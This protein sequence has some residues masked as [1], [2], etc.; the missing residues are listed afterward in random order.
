MGVLAKPSA[1]ACLDSGYLGDAVCDYANWV[2]TRLNVPLALLHAIDQHSQPIRTEYSGNLGMEEHRTLLQDIV[3]TEEK[4]NR[5]LIEQG[6]LLLED[7]KDRLACVRKEEPVLLQRHDGI[8]QTLIDLEGM[9]KI[10]V[11]GIRGESQSTKPR[12][13]GTHLEAIIRAIHRPLFIVNSRF[14]APQKFMIAYDG[15]DTA[16]KII[17]KI[18]GYTAFL[19][20]MEC[21]VVSVSETMAHTR[22]NVVLEDAAHTLTRAGIRVQAYYLS[23][24]IVKTL[25]E[26]QHTHAIDFTVM[27]AFGHSRLRDFLLGSI[28]R[29]MLLNAKKPLLLLR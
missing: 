8:L 15:S 4:R 10:A 29:E 21:H 16:L 9:L 23:G 18:A 13:L 12:K 7:A 27:G 28:T 1:V 17:R 11:I 14:V 26:H 2:S 19:E 24:H 5:L 22:S 20:D 25:C 6:R 3:E